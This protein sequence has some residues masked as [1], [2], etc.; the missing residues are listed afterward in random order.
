MA[1]VVD[2]SVSSTLRPGVGAATQGKPFQRNETMSSLASSMTV[3]AGKLRRNTLFCRGPSTL[4]PC[5][6][7]NS[8][9]PTTSQLIRSEPHE[10]DGT[11]ARTQRVVGISNSGHPSS[12]TH[13]DAVARCC[14]AE[15][16]TL[17]HP[18][19]PGGD[20]A[21][22]LPPST[23]RREHRIAGVLDR[24]PCLG[25]P[26]PVRDVTGRSHAFQALLAQLPF[27][28]KTMRLFLFK[29]RMVLKRS[30]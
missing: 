15:F 9:R 19:V 5:C 7:P 12:R 23:P 22:V 30:N 2:I 21:E 16:Q 14:P 29:Q 8:P 26:S 27:L 13:Q 24:A 17:P 25:R 4:C 6:F 10:F 28:P 20:F 11:I 3:L 18:L 1:K